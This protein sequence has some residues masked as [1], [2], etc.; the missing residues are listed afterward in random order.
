MHS[1]EL[2]EHLAKHLGSIVAHLHGSQRI[3]SHQLSHATTP[4]LALRDSD[5]AVTTAVRGMNQCS[6]VVMNCFC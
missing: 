1:S 6:G 5:A 3:G 2:T 4:I